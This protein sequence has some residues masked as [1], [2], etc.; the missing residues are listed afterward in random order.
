VLKLTG[1]A[2]SLERYLARSAVDTFCYKC[3]LASSP[4]GKHRLARPSHPGVY[5][6]LIERIVGLSYP[7]KT[8]I[9]LP[10]TVF[11]RRHDRCCCDP[12]TKNVAVIGEEAITQ[13]S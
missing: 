3:S 7:R 4:Y 13:V 5:Q 6:I 12:R 9:D 1:C 11:S 8:T 2:N 10:P